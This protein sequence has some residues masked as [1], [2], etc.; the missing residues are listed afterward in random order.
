MH[1][2]SQLQAALVAALKA[3]AALAG[4]AGD[5]VF[6]GAPSG[7]APPYVVV[8]RHDVR[9]RDADLAPGQEHRLQLACWGDQP[10]R[11]RALDIAGRVLAVA[12]ELSADGITV[13]HREHLRTETA[14]DDAT[15]K[16]RA[17]VTLRFFTEG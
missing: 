16:A 11:R 4:I 5:A 14:V 7:R 9:Q 1:P 17:T 12:L 6:D 15:G 8:A 13:T 3:D 10:S 2:I